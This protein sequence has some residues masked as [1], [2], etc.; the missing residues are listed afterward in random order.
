MANS[1]ARARYGQGAVYGSLAYDFSNP[2]LYP[3]LDYSR[4]LDIPAP[5]QTRERVVTKA[6]PRTRQRIAPTAILGFACAA[7]MLVFALMAQIQLT[8]V[9]DETAQL[10]TKLAELETEQT[11]LLIGYESAFNLTEIE[12]YAIGTLGMQKPRSDQVFYIEGGAPDKAVILET[13]QTE[14]QNLLDRIGSIVSGIGEY[15]R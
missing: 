6:M 9:S 4:P 3:E 10:E 14:E 7:V 11:K 5:P 8:A 13:A 12:E 15:F 2:D 1:T